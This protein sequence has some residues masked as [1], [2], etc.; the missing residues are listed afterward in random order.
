MKQNKILTQIL[1]KKLRGCHLNRQTFKKEIFFESGLLLP[2]TIKI[3][4]IFLLN[5]FT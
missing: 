2:E 1:Y 3:Y 4:K 5:A